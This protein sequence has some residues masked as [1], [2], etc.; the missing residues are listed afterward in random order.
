MC[1]VN[2]GD[3]GMKLWVDILRI[4]EVTMKFTINYAFTSTGL[5]PVTM[6][7]LVIVPLINVTLYLAVKAVITALSHSLKFF[8]SNLRAVIIAPEASKGCR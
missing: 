2:I 6:T 4:H 7:S 5:A 8:P 3:I 1:R